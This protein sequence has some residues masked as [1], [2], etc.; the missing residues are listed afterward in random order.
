MKKTF[1]NDY[2]SLLTCIFL[3]ILCISFIIIMITH[4]NDRA[5]YIA[6]FA[7]WGTGSIVC[8]AASIPFWETITIFEDKI[9]S[10]KIYRLTV[11]PFSEIESITVSTWACADGTTA[12]GWIIKST[13]GKTINFVK[14]KR[15]EP[16]IKEIEAMLENK[17]QI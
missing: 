7:I 16:L 5:I 13:D 11:I 9:I 6:A 15:R 8:I 2:H 12:I 4:R 1:L 10:R 17:S 3:L 14:R